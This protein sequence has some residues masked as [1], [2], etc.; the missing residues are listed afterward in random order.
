MDFKYEDL[1]G[2]S[3]FST[4][5]KLMP[6][7]RP[8]KKDLLLIGL[9][10]LL[11]AGVDIVTPLMSGYAVSLFIEPNS[12]DGIGWFAAVCS[13]AAI[14]MFISTVCMCRFAINLEMYISR[15]LKNALFEHLQTLGFDYYNTTPVGTIL[16]RALSDSGKIGTVFAWSLVDIVW[17]MAYVIGAISVMCVI[18]IKLA[19]LIVAIV[20]VVGV[21]TYFFQKKI[22]AANR[23]VLHVN[24]E[25]TSNFN[26]VISGAKTSKTLVIEEKNE[27]RFNAVTEDMRGASVHAVM[28]NAVYVP[29]VSMLTSLAVAFVLTRGGS[30]VI[31]GAIGIG[32][33]TVFI[34]YALVIADPV[35]QFAR[36]LSRFISTQVNVERCNYVLELEP[37]IKDSPEVIEKYGTSFD[38]KRENWEK[39]EGHITFD[40]VTFMYSDGTENVLEHFS[41]DIPAG[42]TVA[43]VGETGAGKSTLV[44]LACRFFEPTAGRIL[45]D[46]RDYRERSM[47]WLHSNIGY[48]L[49]TPHLFS[50][51]VKENIRYGRLDA[52]D[53]EIVAAAKLVS[54]H[55]AIMR[56]ENGYDSDVGEGGDQLSTGEKQ[57][58][59]FARAVLADPRIFVL[60][61]ATANID[62]RTEEL[63]QNAI[64]KLLGSRTSFLI[65]HR[66]STI[67]KADL[68]LVVRGG[69]IMERG[70]HRELMEKGGYY[71]D[72][73]NR[74]FSDENAEKIFSEG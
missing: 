52:T 37:Q 8:Y 26:E 10:M 67:R 16:A 18:N 7:I 4:W 56:M 60:D 55:D 47:L 72:L 71:A 1:K 49:Q 58:I 41:L 51:T 34:N 39:L 46:G 73:Y 63:I 38:P 13:L 50:G 64:S 3:S 19:L 65:A 27:K 22:L 28:L 66:L 21:I 68:I 57:L 62:T 44:N 45:I 14:C 11:G 36:T 70:T 2:T 25:I 33:L 12:T 30:S 35:Q 31:A 48:V 32:E 20:P 24:S 5:K 53:E 17:S 6:F 42:T 29:I 23:R 69:K 9:F 74:Q 61:E 40:D 59:S 43:I 15:D 54:A